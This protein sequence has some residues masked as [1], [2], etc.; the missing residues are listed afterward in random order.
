MSIFLQSFTCEHVP[1]KLV[2]KRFRFENSWLLEPDL[3]AVVREAW[4]QTGDGNLVE[5]ITAC[6]NALQR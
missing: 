4:D 5:K 3:D 2:H 1:P 6:T